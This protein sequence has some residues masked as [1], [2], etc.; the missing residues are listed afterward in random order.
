VRLDRLT[1]DVVDALEGTVMEDARLVVG[2]LTTR[3]ALEAGGDERVDVCV[4]LEDAHAEDRR[5]RRARRASG[6]DRA[7]A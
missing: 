2:L 5:G 7:A 1:L 6:A 4:V 3:S